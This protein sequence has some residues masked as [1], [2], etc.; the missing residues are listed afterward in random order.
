MPAAADENELAGAGRGG[1]IAEMDRPRTNALD[2]AL[3]IEALPGIHHFARRANCLFPVPQ[4]ERQTDTE[5]QN[6]LPLVIAEI[7]GQRR[8][9]ACDERHDVVRSRIGIGLVKLGAHAPGEVEEDKVSASPADLDADEIGSLGI[10]R[11]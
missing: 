2:A 7:A 5:A 11:E 9:A 10:E 1:I 4:L 3:Q 6:M 8:E